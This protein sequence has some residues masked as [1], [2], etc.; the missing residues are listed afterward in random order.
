MTV[1]KFKHNLISVFDKDVYGYKCSTVFFISFFNLLPKNSKILKKKNV[2]KLKSRKFMKYQV[3][4]NL[5][6]SILKERIYVTPFTS[7]FFK[8]INKNLEVK[9]F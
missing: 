8:K 9:P 2:F 6:N 3:N 4:Y 1:Y 5:N 7:H